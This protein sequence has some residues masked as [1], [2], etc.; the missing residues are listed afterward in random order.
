VSTVP[1]IDLNT[2]IEV[3]EPD[4][5]LALLAGEEVGR[6]GVVIGGYAEIFP[7]NYVADPDGIV[8]GTEAGSKLAAACQGPVVFEVDELDR[9]NKSAWSVVIHG[10]AHELP[11]VEAPA[12]RLSMSRVS[13]YPWTG[14]VKP[15]LVRVVPTTI[16]GRRIRGRVVRER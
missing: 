10:R 11:P 2:G 9:A 8:F 14:V 1:S 16:T 7:V 3:I 4:E 15:Y 13:L 6:L 5:C 12:L